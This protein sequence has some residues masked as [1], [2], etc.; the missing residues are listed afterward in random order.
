MMVKEAN[1]EEI[2]QVA[3][4]AKKCLRIKGEERP[5]MKEVAMELERVRSMQ[6]QHSWINNNNLSSTEE[7]VCFL[8]VEASDSNHFAL[9]GTMHTVGDNIKARTILSNIH[10]GR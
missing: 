1:F 9:S 8:D 2:K 6:V 10:H 4:V 3:K 5:N 7:M